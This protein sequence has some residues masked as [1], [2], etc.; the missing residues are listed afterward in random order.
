MPI[1]VFLR[2]S[3]LDRLGPMYVTDRRQ[4]DVRRA[5]TLNDALAAGA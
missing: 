2:L 5:S 1:L 4:T 3:V